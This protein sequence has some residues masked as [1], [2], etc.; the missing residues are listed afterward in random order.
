MKR[1]W[2]GL[3]ILLLI[4]GCRKPQNPDSAPDI[5]ADELKFH[6]YR[7]ASDSLE[8]RSP[9]TRGDS[10]AAAHIADAFR[11]YGLSPK[12]DS[13][14]FQYFKIIS[15]VTAGDENILRQENNSFERNKDF[16]PYTFSSAD[17]VETTAVFAGYGIEA[18][19]LKYNDYANIDVKGKVVILLRYGPDGDNRESPFANHTPVRRKATAAAEKG[20]AAVL[21]TTGFLDGDDD[22]PPLRYDMTSDHYGIPV[23]AITRATAM[24]ILNVT[25]DQ[26]SNAQKELNHRKKI[27][28]LVSQK[29]LYIQSKVEF[30]RSKTSNIIGFLE[31]SIRHGHRGAGPVDRRALRP[32]RLG[33]RELNLSRGTGHPQRRG[34]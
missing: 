33:R 9:G 15:G 13:G 27:S 7:L 29:P 25:P 3:F 14:Y 24:T 18:P 17:T 8:G 34:R 5:T 31:V 28:P 6:V 12:G 20:A 23:F 22:L 32:S 19:D 2:T 1:Y 26:F 4:A 16:I 21:I 10:L 30:N 11:E